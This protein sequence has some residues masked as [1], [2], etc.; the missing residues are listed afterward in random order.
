MCAHITNGHHCLNLE[1]CSWDRTTQMCVDGALPCYFFKEES[2]CIESEDCKWF[3]T[4]R[5][6]AAAN[7]P[8]WP[9]NTYLAPT[10]DPTESPYACIAEEEEDQPTCDGIMAEKECVLLE[11]CLWQL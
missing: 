9:Y 5:S 3:T 1:G 7:Y 2:V 4:S 8:V 10:L 6:K 11:D